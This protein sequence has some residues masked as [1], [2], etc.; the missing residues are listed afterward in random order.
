MAGVSTSEERRAI[1]VPD[2]G[3]VSAAVVRPG[4]PF[5]WLAL[6]HGAGAGM[7]HPFMSG[8]A[9][10]IADE[11]VATLRCNFPYMEA[12]KRSPDR[13]P[14]AVATVGAAFEAAATE[15]GDGVP[16]WVGG[17]SF[18]GRMAS[19]AVAEGLPAGGLVFLGYP[20]HPPGKPDRVRDEH[21]YGIGVPMLFLQGTRDPFATHSVLDP[22]I[23]KLPTATLHPVDGGG[24]SL[25]RSRKDDAREVAAS[26]APLVA[27]FM[28]GDAA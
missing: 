4:A 15:A 21:L 11:G 19:V 26:F 3:Q 5:G 23:A 20:L 14:V 25:E 18:G 24:H 9:R 17:K 16:V 7:D 10:A 8:F 13:P 27:G 2:A 12:G 22:V 28:R 1:D 6:F